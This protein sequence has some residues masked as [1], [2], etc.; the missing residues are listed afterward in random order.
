MP[1]ITV[2]LQV[3]G[4]I[5]RH[6]TGGSQPRGHDCSIGPKK[7]LR[8]HQTNEGI[9]SYVLLQNYFGTFL[10]FLFFSCKNTEYFQLVRTPFRISNLKRKNPSLVEFPITHVHTEPISLN[11]GHK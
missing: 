1:S 4:D 2:V 7:N 8:G 10:R 3:T 5:L 6:Y 11:G 9:T